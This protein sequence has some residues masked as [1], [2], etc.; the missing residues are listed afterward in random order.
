VKKRFQKMLIS[1]GIPLA[2]FFVAILFTRS[3]PYW[4]WHLRHGFHTES[5]GVR[6]WVPYLYRAYEH[7][8]RRSLTLM[9]WP[10]FFP[11]PRD[12]VNAGT[13]MIDFV[14]TNQAQRPLMILLGSGPIQLN[15]DGPFT[16]SSERKLTMAGRA[17]QCVEYG[18]GPGAGTNLLVDDHTLKIYCWFGNDMRASFLGEI[19]SAGRFYEVIGSARAAEGAR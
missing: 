18:I 12:A 4:T 3:A 6:I 17:G 15:L 19:S 13:I 11:A 5:N 9:A 7:T 2:I 10:G 16:K 8:D 14:E 1:V